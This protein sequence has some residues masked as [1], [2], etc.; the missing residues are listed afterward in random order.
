MKFFISIASYCDEL[1]FFTLNDCI[2]KANK[3]ENIFFGIVD[4]NETTQKEKIEKL[5][6]NKQIR[7]VY[8]NNIDTQGVCWARNIAFSLWDGE[9]YL[10]QIDS[11]ML[12]EKDWDTTLI[13]QYNELKKI[14]DKPIITTYP[15]NFSFDEENNP[16]FKKQSDKY[17]LVLRPHPDTLLEE[18][19]AVLRFRAEHKL[20][21]K[22]VLGCH[23]AGGFIFTSSDFIEEVPYDPFLYFH[24]EEQ[25]IAIRAYT[26]G[27]DI[28]HPNKIPMHH[29][30]KT[31]NTEYSSQHWNK[32]VESK[33]TLSAS[34]LKIRAIKRINRLFYGDGMRDSIYGLGDKR[35]LDEYINLSGIDYKNK[36]ILSL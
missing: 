5:D 7:Y 13:N 31:I 15:Y 12:F 28:Y 20:T 11:H 27:W 26:R 18:E 9:D 25:S 2:S 34:Y 29:H 17:V 14:S 8:I 36:T 4:Q 23:V 30:Y 16:V 3:P 21:D 35:T 24:G 6:F 19:N 1:L 32:S 33:R 10:L 22:P